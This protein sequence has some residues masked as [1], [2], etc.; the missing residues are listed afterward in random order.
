MVIIKHCTSQVYITV[1]IAVAIGQYH[2]LLKKYFNN[3]I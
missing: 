3:S 2:E 1:S